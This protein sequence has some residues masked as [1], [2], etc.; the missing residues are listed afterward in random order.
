MYALPAIT[1]PEAKLPPSAI[2]RNPKR[3]VRTPSAVTIPANHFAVRSS[4]FTVFPLTQTNP[5]RT[6]S[7]ETA[8]KRTLRSRFRITSSASVSETETKLQNSPATP[9]D[10]VKVT[11]GPLSLPPSYVVSSN[12][13]PRTVASLGARV[14]CVPD[15]PT[16][17]ISSAPNSEILL[18]PIS[19]KPSNRSV[20]PRV[21]VTCSS[22]R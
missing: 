5:R 15:G 8:G 3:S 10:C 9:S 7:R 20:S 16:T 12:S 13:F 17:V 21:S 22:L 11:N 2:P 19:R 18:V 1:I 6:T 4:R 14:M